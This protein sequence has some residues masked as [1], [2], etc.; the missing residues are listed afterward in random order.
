MRMI[1][2]SYLV[3]AMQ[4]VMLR[5]HGLAELTGPITVLLLTVVIGAWV[6]SRLFR[7]EASE[8]LNKR[9][10]VTAVVV[11]TLLY[12]AAALLAPAFEMVQS[13]GA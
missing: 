13:P 8:P 12:A 2:S 4:G 1:P 5:G 7:W 10:M 9:A 3:E 6:N 11:L